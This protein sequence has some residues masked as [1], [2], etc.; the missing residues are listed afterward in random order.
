MRHNYRLF[1][2][3]L[4]ILALALGLFGLTAPNAD[5]DAPIIHVVGWGDTLF[6]IATRYGTT[7]NAIMQAN[8]IRNADF[9]YVGERL[10]ISGGAA[11]IPPAPASSYV[12]QNGDTLFSIATRYGTTVNELMQAN[13]LYNYWIFVGQTLKISGQPMP[14]PVPNPNPMPAPNPNP[15][16]G[17]YYI[18]RSGDYLGLIAARFGTTAYAIQ[19]ANRL[20]NASFIWVGQRLL[21]P[22]G[23]PMNNPNPAPI[24]NPLPPIYVP[25][26]ISQPV[27]INPQPLPQVIPPAPYLPTAVPVVLPPP[28]TPNPNPIW[29]A[30]LITN[31]VGHGPCS[32]AAIVVGKDNWPVVVATTDGSWISDPKMTGTKPEKGPYAVEFAHAC[33]GV[34]R[35]I[36]LG[37]N[38][39]ADVQ[40]NGGHA[41]VEF[42]PRP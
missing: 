26:V 6:S 17:T 14:G 30:V 16:P 5:A 2:V 27:L 7:V 18:V 13:G 38:I 31:T 11:P 42:H 4:A 22:G 32:L 37:L 1:L 9:I 40:L 8:G 10:T 25:P 35:V 33:T 3:T 29:E 21:I 36:P 28:V 34:W 23:L 39:Y 15:Q 12:V 20:P 19:L 41:E 24:Y